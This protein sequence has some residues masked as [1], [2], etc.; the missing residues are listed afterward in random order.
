VEIEGCA[1]P[2]DRLYDLEHDV[3]WAEEPVGGIARVGIL[4][5]LGA[6]AGPFQTVSFRPVEG[7]LGQGRS[8]ATVESYRYTGAV[9]LPVDAML[10]EKN[11]ALVRRPR[12]LN[13]APYGD[14]WVV[15]VR[16]TH[17]EDI[18]HRLETASAVA[19]RLEERIRTQRI[20]CWPVTPELEMFEIGLECSAVITKLNEELASRPAGQAIL[21][22]TDDPTSPIE[23]VRWSDQ[24]G[25]P[26][27][28]HR[29]EGTLHHFLI[30]KEAHPQPRRPVR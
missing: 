13:D 12:L 21:L 16:A 25:H 4:A 27:L 26:V 28:A 3:W 1:L 29:R 5:T 9:R 14:G 20:R 8:V 22:V 19:T 18:G 30:R 10:V 17:P 11:E 2:E 24:T 15:R 7:T 23:M 6:F